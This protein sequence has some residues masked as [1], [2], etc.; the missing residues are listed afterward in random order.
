LAFRPGVKEQDTPP[1]RH[2]ILDG[3]E[4]A[5]PHDDCNGVKDAI[6]RG[7][8]GG[9]APQRILVALDLKPSQTLT[10]NRQIDSD[11]SATQPELL[12]Q[13]GCGVPFEGGI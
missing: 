10:Y 11:C 6:V 4:V 1:Q 8:L 7:C 2:Y 5:R 3:S 9:Q 12:D 13:H